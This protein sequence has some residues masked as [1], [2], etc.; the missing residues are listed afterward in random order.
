MIL[1]AIEY[2]RFVPIVKDLLPVD[3][4]NDVDDVVE[5]LSPS[6]PD[7]PDEPVEPELPEEPVLPELP[8]EPDE[9]V[10]P[11]EPLSPIGP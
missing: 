8:L 10:V 7:E 6:W 5:Y 3:I 1:C 11:D 2:E 4:D 9:P